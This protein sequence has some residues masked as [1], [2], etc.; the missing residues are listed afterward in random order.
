M[1]AILTPSAP[2]RG[3]ATAA[4]GVTVGFSPYNLVS[5]SL[6]GMSKGIKSYAGKFG[7]AV[8]LADPNNSAT[9]QVQQLQQ[10][11]DLGEVK[12]AWVLALDPKTLVP[13][14]K[15]AQ[16]HHVVLN[17]QGT[18]ANYGQKGPLPGISF[19]VLNYEKFGA[20]VGKSLG[21]CINQRLGGKGQV[22]YIANP[23][24]SVGKASEDAAF[25]KALK[26]TSPR[27]RIIATSDSG[28]V[29][30]TAQQNS[31]SAI[32]GHPGINAVAGVTDEGSLGSL[33][34][35]KLSGKNPKTSSCAVGAG[36]NAQGLADVKS[37]LE[38]AYTVIGFQA[39]LEQEV[40][41][42]ITM[43]KHP[44]AVGKVLYTPFSV[45]SKFIK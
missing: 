4:A 20:A 7:V 42:V 15:I 33:A 35:L 45:E 38:Y 34:A 6:I 2:A 12:G 26:Q 36:G 44:T 19:D 37:K 43:A 17:L 8:R 21:A 13:L 10:W 18:P 23:P 27:S 9:T 11:I 41:A 39:D 29:Q 22:L 5:P 32:Q 31:L 3:R 14:I 28:N 16:A 30:L 24:G 25:A 1:V 40:R